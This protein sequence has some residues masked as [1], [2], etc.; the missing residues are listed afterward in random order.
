VCRGSSDPERSAI[1]RQK[2]YYLD[3]HLQIRNA[4]VD[5]ASDAFPAAGASDWEK[6]VDEVLTVRADP[7]HLHRIF[8]NLF[9]A[10]QAIKRS[11]ARVLSVEADAGAADQDGQERIAFRVDDPGPGLPCP[12]GRW[13]ACSSPSPHR[14]RRAAPGSASRS[15]A[16]SP[17][18]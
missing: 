16:S 3:T 13:S 10:L 1:A 15:R 9:P 14:A 12:S 7:D 5:A 17:A 4:L 11:E 2:G 8:L 18:P 6:R